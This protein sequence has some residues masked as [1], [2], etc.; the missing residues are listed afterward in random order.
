[1]RQALWLPF[2][3]SVVSLLS[4]CEN[5]P[6]V[7]AAMFADQRPDAEIISGFQTIYSDSAQIKIRISGDLMLRY[8]EDGQFIQQFPEGLFVEFFDDQGNITST[9]ASKYGIRNEAEESV[10]VQDSVVWQATRGDRLDTD[11]LVW[12]AKNEKI[13]SDKFVRV[14]QGDKI[15]TGVG[16]ESNQD[17]TRSKVR[18]IQGVVNLP[19]ER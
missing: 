18:A 3:V 12:E 15:I 5:D 1:M 6:S 19:K 7:V 8:Q 14:L 17:F 13:Y 4:A 9:L 16:F 11:E 10:L 2:L